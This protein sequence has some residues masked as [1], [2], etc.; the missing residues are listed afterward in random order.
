M[1]TATPQ[2]RAGWRLIAFLLICAWAG[3]FVYGRRFPPATEVRAVLLVPP[4]TDLETLCHHPEIQRA[5]SARMAM[6]G[7]LLLQQ[8]QADV[9]DS[10]KMSGPLTVTKTR[11]NV[12]ELSLISAMPERGLLELEALIEVLSEKLAVSNGESVNSFQLKLKAELAELQNRR[13][14]AMSERETWKSNHPDG[15][16]D[17]QVDSAR[18][19]L[20]LLEKAATQARLDRLQAEHDLEV[21]A[22]GLQTQTPIEALA[23]QLSAPV[24]KLAAARVQK[25]R[26]QTE[27]LTR[28]SKLEGDYSA[29][30]GERHP[31]LLQLR[32]QFEQVLSALGGWEN[33][34]DQTSVADRM[35]DQAEEAL[36]VL[37][38]QGTDLQNQLDFEKSALTELN[39]DELYDNQL[40]A[41][42]KKLDADIATC[43]TR[44]AQAKNAA[45]SEV[46]T[47]KEAP[48]VSTLVRRQELFLLFFCATGVALL[49][50]FGLNR[51]VSFRIP[52]DEHR[53][54][55]LLT[56]PHIK[57]NAEPTLGLAERRALRKVRLELAGN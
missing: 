53:P 23:K 17:V 36:A 51:L 12:W 46:I 21:L 19:R 45:Q 13:D 33:T 15:A 57:L 3:C 39:A 11:T 18:E 1:T 52:H 30:Y 34:L 48:Y 14:L 5:A 7:N 38:Q 47:V 22:R 50:G 20:R 9:Q 26:Q 37:L 8:P 40:D 25:Q 27:E 29:V 24:I 43:S 54:L 10:M 31:K 41:Q 35:L 16:R 2:R 42:L 6:S 44:I 28:L 49:A 4:A 32:N 55:P 56:V